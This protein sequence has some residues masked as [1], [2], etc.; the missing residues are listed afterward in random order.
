MQRILIADDEP[1][2]RAL[3]RM[4]L[5]SPDVEMLEAP[6]GARALELAREL[7]PD[8]ILLDASMPAMSGVE[9]CRTLQ[10]EPETRG[11]PV[12]MLSGWSEQADLDAWTEA[13]ATGSLAKPFSPAVLLE[14]VRSALGRT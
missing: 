1:G 11:L 6:D 4:T 3:V 2:I 5:D 14:T 13:G 9:V 10:Q 7:R 12:I 8:L